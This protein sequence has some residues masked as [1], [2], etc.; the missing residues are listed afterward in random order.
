MS[1]LTAQG[2]SRILVIE[3]EHK[4]A[5]V[6]M[7]ALSA[8]GFDVAMAPT[9]I[10][11]LGLIEKGAYG[12]VILDLLLP[13]ID[14][15]SVLDRLLVIAPGQAVLVLSSLADVRAK[16]RCLELGACDYVTKPFDLPELIARVRLRIHERRQAD[17]ERY[18][19]H[20]S[21]TLDTQRRVVAD[22]ERQV[23]LATRE[24]LLLEYLMRKPGEVCSRP[25]LLEHVWGYSFDPG[26][27]VVDVCIRR[28]RA[29]LGDPLIET[30]RNVGYSLAAA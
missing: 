24:Y 20:S 13:D 3:D 11:G 7:R 9:A 19:R 21:L 4:I 17:E 27:N 15:F 22:G 10:R 25:E 2:G 1:A 6:V 26:T 18:L 28:L 8:A 14:G 29:K 30:I 5:S 12:L 16:V 23:A